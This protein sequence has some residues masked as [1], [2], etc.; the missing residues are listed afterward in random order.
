M[1]PDNE[2]WITLRTTIDS[3]G[4]MFLLEDFKL[5]ADQWYHLTYVFDEQD[6]GR[7]IKIYING[8]RVFASRVYTNVYRWREDNMILFGGAAFGRAGL[9]GTLDEYRIY[10]KA[11]SQEEV[12]ASIKYPETIPEGL[13]GYWNFETDPA[14]DGKLFSSGKDTSIYGGLFQ[15]PSGESGSEFINVPMSFLPGVPFIAGGHCQIKTLP[16]WSFSD[17]AIIETAPQGDSSKGS[18]G[19]S[20]HSAGDEAVT[21]TLQ[22]HWGKASKTFR[23]IKVNVE[24]SLNETQ[25]ADVITYPNPFI[26]E[27]NVQFEQDGIYTIDVISINGQLIM[28]RQANISKGEFVCLKIN[29]EPEHYLIKIKHEN[30][31]IKTIPVIK[32]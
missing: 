26:D 10:D 11:I 17:K 4:A 6:G 16:A 29:A 21:L 15:T 9:D 14:D 20:Y 3:S 18:V 22:N 28:S 27:V 1:N 5:R 19:L 25:V 31:V 23:Y 24:S 32:R 30:K 7:T 13:I 12:H 2:F 8:R